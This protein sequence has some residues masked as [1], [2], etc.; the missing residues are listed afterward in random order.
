MTF[1]GRLIVRTAPTLASL[2][3]RLPVYDT[4]C[5]AKMFRAND[6]V[7]GLFATPFVSNWI[8]DV[9][10]LGRLVAAVGDAGKAATMVYEYPLPEWHD[11]AGSKLGTGHMLAALRDLLHIRRLYRP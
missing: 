2:T 4:Q 5:G 7:H 1:P 8:F 10:I 11:V 3:L 6:L 9:E